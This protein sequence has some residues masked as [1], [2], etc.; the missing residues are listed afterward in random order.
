MSKNIIFVLKVMWIY[1][2]WDG[3]RF[4]LS[5]QAN[6]PIKNL[7]MLHWSFFQIPYTLAFMNTLICNISP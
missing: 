2:V 7:E 6:T 4:Y 1:G 3:L 5:S